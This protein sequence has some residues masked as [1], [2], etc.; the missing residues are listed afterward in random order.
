[1]LVEPLTYF[2]DVPTL[3][4]DGTH[5]LAIYEWGDKAGETVFCVH[6]LT[7]NGRDFDVIASALAADYRVI[8]LDVAGRGKSQWH[9]DPAHYNYPEYI[10]DIGHIV[11]Q[12]N[13]K[14]IHWVGTSM[15]G[16][17]GMMAANHFPGLLKTLTLNDIG[18]LIPAAGLARVMS[19]A[20]VSTVFES[21]ALAEAELRSRCATYG[22]KA[23]ANWQDLFAHS[24][25][26]TNDGKFRLAYDPA[27]AKNLS[28][29]EK[30]IEDVNLWGLWEAVKPIPTLLIHGAESD[31]LTHET[32]MQM[33]QS[34]PDFSLLE[35]ENTGHAPALMDGMQINAIK[36][37]IE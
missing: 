10:A 11:N 1:M 5:R 25:E 27:I 24:I 17:M 14:N 31:I 6:G 35:I 19:Y 13:L 3:N 16:I 34:H 23:E 2:L 28:A 7:R 22:I 33:L 4:S 8:S 9:S 12:L 26:K 18:C 15:G 30:P 29:P 21:R 37:R 32:C 36:K 20:G